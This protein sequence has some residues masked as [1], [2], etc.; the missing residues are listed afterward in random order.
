[1]TWHYNYRERDAT[2]S[3]IAM[4]GCFIYL[5]VKRRTQIVDENQNSE[6]EKTFQGIANS[7][8]NM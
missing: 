8:V 1:M 7:E 6:V 2:P 3:Q 5:I 4:N